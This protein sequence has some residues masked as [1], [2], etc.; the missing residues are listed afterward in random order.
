VVDSGQTSLV[1]GGLSHVVIVWECEV[2][3]VRGW[4]DLR[5]TV[6]D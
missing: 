3:I 6:V 1:Q 4:G 5:E 2:G